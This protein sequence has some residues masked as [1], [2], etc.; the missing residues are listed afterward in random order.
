MGEETGDVEDL[1]QR[2]EPAGSCWSDWGGGPARRAGGGYGGRL[3]RET[4][5]R[6]G[7]S[8]ARWERNERKNDEYSMDLEC[9]RGGGRITAERQDELRNK[10]VL[11]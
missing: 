3:A 9:V 2:D 6:G 1:G 8:R 7:R 5:E 4:R 11:H 10:I